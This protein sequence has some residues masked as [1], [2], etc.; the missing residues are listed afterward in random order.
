MNIQSAIS[1]EIFA[2]RDEKLL[3]AIEVRRRT[4]RKGLSFL[5]T[6]RKKD[7]LTYLCLSVTNSRPAQVL[8]TKVKRYRGTRQLAKRSQ[9]SVEQLRQVNGINPE[10]DTPEFD[11]VLDRTTDQWVASSAAEKCM[12]VQV[13]YH[14]CR[15]YWEAKLAR[16]EPASPAEQKTP[17]APE[18]K[19]SPG[20]QS[21]TSFINCQQKL[22][23]DACSV[24]M[25]IYRCKIFL[26]RMK[27]SMTANQGQAQRQAAA[28][29][30]SRSRSRSSPSPPA[31][32]KMGSVMRR[33]SQ[34]LSERGERL[35]RA[36]EKT[37]HLLHGAKQFAEAAQK[38]ALKQI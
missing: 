27:N 33:A 21:Q 8:I 3:V 4:K 6:G 34:V 38:L 36:D 1:R 24:N 20:A 37:S 16:T 25:V 19:K 13:L 7:Y 12:F 9:W 22:M 23:G 28:V 11:L 5:N 32:R 26:N 18:N 15:N 10:K 2:P 17:G 14:A 30:A 31:V 35:M 29:K